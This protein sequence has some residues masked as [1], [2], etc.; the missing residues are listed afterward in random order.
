MPDKNCV[1]ERRLRVVPYYFGVLA[2]TFILIA[3]SVNS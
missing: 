1:N 2:I 3:L